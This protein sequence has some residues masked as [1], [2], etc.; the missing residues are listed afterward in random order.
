MKTLTVIQSIRGLLTGD[1]RRSRHAVP[2][3]KS[4]AL[5]A[6]LFFAGA[7]LSVLFLGRPFQSWS[8]TPTSSSLL[9]SA[10]G[11]GDLTRGR[12]VRDPTARPHYT[13]ATCAFIEGY[14]NCM[15]HGKPST[16]F[17]RWRWQPDG[18]G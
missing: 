10:G 11:A 6:V 8:P 18:G 15:K 13:N 4:A 16:E 1:H 7:T 9:S 14:Q 3:I 2:K 17:L 12:W 5:A